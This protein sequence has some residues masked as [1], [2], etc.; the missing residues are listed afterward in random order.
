MPRPIDLL[1]IRRALAR[2][3]QIAVD[4]PEYCQ[5]QGQWDEPEVKKIM[6]TPINERM[7]AYRARLRERGW[8]QVAMYLSPE[9]LARLDQLREQHPA[10]SIGE[11]VSAALVADQ[12]S[13]DRV[14]HPTADYQRENPVEERPHDPPR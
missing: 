4:H 12:R 9:A 8:R 13:V 14:I 2:W 6:G 7:K 3:D 10:Q 5:G 1:R 11:L